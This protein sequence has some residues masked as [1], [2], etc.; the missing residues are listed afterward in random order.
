MAELIT[1]YAYSGSNIEYIGEAQPG[2]AAA[3][4]RWR[5]KKLTYSGDNVVSMH[6]AS[7]TEDFDKT[8]DDRAT[9][10]YS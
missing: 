7:G 10:T 3:D 8:W 5:I 2:T 1:R 6:W 9:Y 4:N